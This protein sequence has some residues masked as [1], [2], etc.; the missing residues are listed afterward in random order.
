MAGQQKILVDIY[1]ISV[2]IDFYI[3]SVYIDIYI[4]S[5]YIDFYIISVY[6]SISVLCLPGFGN[7]SWIY[8]NTVGQN[9][10]FA[11]PNNIE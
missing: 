1:I 7:K 4:I 9:K 6:I 3:I 11:V 8:G 5:V 10:L 2:S